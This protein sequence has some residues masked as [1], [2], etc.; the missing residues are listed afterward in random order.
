MLISTCFSIKIASSYW[1]NL[2]EGPQRMTGQ[3]G[4]KAGLLQWL[5]EQKAGGSAGGFWSEFSV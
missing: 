3:A 1:G 2:H 5:R 4:A